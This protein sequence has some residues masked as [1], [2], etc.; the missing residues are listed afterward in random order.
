MEILS[1]DGEARDLY[2]FPSHDASPQKP[3]TQ[4]SAI[5]F[6]QV[7]STVASLGPRRHACVLLTARPNYRE[8]DT[9]GPVAALR[10]VSSERCQLIYSILTPHHVP[11]ASGERAGEVQTNPMNQWWREK[12][13]DPSLAGRNPSL[14]VHHTGRRSF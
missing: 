8:M 10:S 6:F 3:C 14:R 11:Q 1:L 9:S 5:F 7:P 12:T 2:T 13:V 4:S